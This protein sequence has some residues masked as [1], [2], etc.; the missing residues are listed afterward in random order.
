M[1]RSEPLAKELGLMKDRSVLWH[2]YYVSA[3]GKERRPII[4][5]VF[6]L[7]GRKIETTANVSDRSKLKEKLLVGR[8]DLGTFLVRPG[9]T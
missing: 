4:P 1:D 3:L 9:T 7:G 2:D 5:I 8:R 6:W